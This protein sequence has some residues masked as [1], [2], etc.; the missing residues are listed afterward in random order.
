MKYTVK[1]NDKFK[2]ISCKGYNHIFDKHTGLSIR[3]GE[4]KEEDPPFS[5]V[6]PEILDWE[7]STICDK[8]GGNC[9]F[10]Y[11]SNT[12]KGKNLDFDTFKEAF[13]KLPASICQVAYGIGS[14]KECDSLFPILKHTRE[15]GVIPNLT[16]NGDITDK[17]ANDFSKVL[18]AIA[19]SHYSDDSCFNAVKKLTDASQQPEATL[20]QVNIHALWSAST[21]DKCFNLLDKIKTD[22]RLFNLNALV[23]LS[24]KPK[25][26][27]RFL[28]SA[29]YEDFKRLVLTA[30]E[31]GVSLGM[32]SCSAP[33]MLR[34]ACETGQEELISS[35]E[36]CESFGLFSA[37]LNVDCDYFPCS[38]A[39]GENGWETG[40]SLLECD[41]FLKDI[42]YSKKVNEWR[43]KSLHMTDDCDCPV[44]QFCRFC[45]IFD[46]TPC[47]LGENHEA[48]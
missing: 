4:T 29:S 14:I 22:E 45:P 42:W 12:K 38:F 39:E 7:I 13:S 33:Q 48:R 40:I 17:E 1:E 34:V 18:G 44:K 32:D 24:L 21:V 36:P 25:G 8:S 5:P 16:C 20:K 6:G 3:Y 28:A 31:K 43:N 26:R 35:I 15:K 19:V 30:Q 10:C 37:Y 9:A 41:N 2:I 11:K 23:L 27:G 46:I 47:K